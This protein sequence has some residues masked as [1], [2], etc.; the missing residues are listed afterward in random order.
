MKAI[1]A[2]EDLQEVIKRKQM[3][4]EQGLP[5]SSDDDDLDSDNNEFQERSKGGTKTNS[6]HAKSANLT[7]RRLD[8]RDIPDA[9]PLL[10]E[11]CQRLQ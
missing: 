5:E 7:K 4:I 2:G 9:A 10:E 3:R 11:A 8:E 1:E 6:K